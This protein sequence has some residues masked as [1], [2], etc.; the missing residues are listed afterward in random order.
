[1]KLF[2]IIAEGGWDSVVTQST[3]ITPSVVKLALAQ[4]QKLIGAINISLAAKGIPP[5]R[6]GA[7]VGSSAYH[8]VDSEDKKY[9]DIDLQIVVPDLPELQDKSTSQQQLYWT[10]LFTEIIATQNLSYV[11]PSSNPGHPILQVGP[12]SWVQVDFLPHPESLETWGRFRATPERGIKGLLTGNMF[13]VLGDILTMSIQYAGVQFKVKDG[14]KV[15]YSTTRKDFTTETISTNIETFL[16]DIFLHDYEFITGND[17]STARISPLL[18]QNPGTDTQ[19]VNI[20][21]LARGIQGLAASYELNKM[22]GR[23]NL[24]NYASKEEFIGAFLARYSQKSAEA[25]QNKKYDKAASPSAIA[26]V[27]KDKE[28]IEQGTAMVQGYFQ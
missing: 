17:S 6:V 27:A 18:S 16:L 21:R 28:N 24:S 14:A 5:V 12:D 9:G 2:E 23:E 3:D 7:P 8:D 15:P 1:M 11:H 25:V 13:S 4:A 19:H 22:Y 20:K 26:K 10:R